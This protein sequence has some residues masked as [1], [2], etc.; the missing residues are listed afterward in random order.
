MKLTKRHV[1]FTSELRDQLAIYFNE[2]GYYLTD[3]EFVE[4]RYD[5]DTY[6]DYVW[7]YAGE[8]KW[9]KKFS[10]MIECART[11]KYIESYWD[12]YKKTPLAFSEKILLYT[13]SGVPYEKDPV[14][15]AQKNPTRMEIPFDNCSI[16]DISNKLI[17]SWETLLKPRL[18]Q[19]SHI[20]KLDSV[21][22]KTLEKID[23]PVHNDGIWF[24]KMIIAKLAGNPMYEDIYTYISQLYKKC[25]SDE[26]MSTH[27]EYYKTRLWV[28]E[29][30]YLKL[31]DVKPLDNTSLI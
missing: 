26:T 16:E 18:D 10:T 6:S 1:K 20:D 17:Y 5:S 22:N 28:V 3:K 4:F 31:R 8:D 24:Y 27:K 23:F 7:L 12:E 19:Y 2:H 21:V 13:F 25:I 30:L 9:K 14:S 11:I 15:H 29:Q